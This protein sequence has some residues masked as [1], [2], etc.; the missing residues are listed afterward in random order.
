MISI[1]WKLIRRVNSRAPPGPPGSEILGWRPGLCM[2][3]SL[4]G[5]PGP[6]LDLRTTDLGWESLRSG[7]QQGQVLVRAFFV[8]CGHQARKVKRSPSCCVLVWWKERDGGRP[9]FQPHHHPIIIT[10]G[11]GIQ[12]VNF[13]GTQTF[14]PK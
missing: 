9:Y 10:L 13:Q 8:T 1:T 14:A 3:R 11:L 2:L 7:C 5:D 4:L 6:H 12:H